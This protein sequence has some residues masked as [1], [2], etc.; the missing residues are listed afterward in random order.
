MKDFEL[1]ESAPDAML[2]ANGDGRV[3]FANRQA[4]HLFGYARHELLSQSVDTLVPL[5]VRAAHRR[6]RQTYMTAART[7][8]MGAAFDLFACRKDGT[9]I[10]VE[11]S[12]S[13]LDSKDG[14][15]VVA[16][17]RD[18]SD[19]KRAE[20]A[21]RD[22][23][24]RYASL[25]R[26]ATYG[27]YRTTLDGRFLD[28]NPALVSMLGYSHEAD[29]LDLNAAEMYVD[30]GDRVRLIERYRTS[31]IVPPIEAQWKRRDGR[32]IVVRLSGRI[33]RNEVGGPNAFEMIAE[34]VTDR[35]IAEERLRTAEKL[36]A[37]ARLTAG[38]AHNFNNL[39][40]VLVGSLELIRAQIT[41]E[42]PV[43]HDLVNALDAARK[44]S[45]VVK[46]MLEFGKEA[47]GSP[48]PLDL[49]QAL[50]ALA[51]LLNSWGMENISVVVQ[52]TAPLPKVLIDPTQLE[53]IV[54]SLLVNARD[55]M[56][57]GGTF[58]IASSLDPTGDRVRLTATDTG[59]GIDEAVL[60]RI[61]DPFFTTRELGQGVGLGLSAVHG[62]VKRSGGTITVQSQRNRGT[63][64]TIDWPAV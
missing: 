40:A 23:E 38:V 14:P 21:L 10:P 50:E 54:V 9:E 18:I 12:L 45:V 58:T 13:P 34:D 48:V 41:P 52:T 31:H 29:L 28:V 53:A 5:R 55:A 43:H 22:S 57:N 27:I 20:Q 11:I 47:E 44:A 59:A 17:V 2:I 16:A 6:H 36:E 3:V 42:S 46:N 30:A 61:F 4:E 56:P 1:L 26:G 24:S 62:L 8:S 32:P 35:R 64:F 51:P 7:R 33:L 15:L 49:N 60:P 19:R 25:V 63:V 37:V 39:L